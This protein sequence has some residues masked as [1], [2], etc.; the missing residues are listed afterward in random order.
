LPRGIEGRQQLAPGVRLGC[1][2]PHWNLQ[3][4]EHR[5][6]L[7]AARHNLRARQRG[8][9]R[10]ARTLPLD[11]FEQRARADAGEQNDDVELIA[12]QS[13]GKG[14]RF[15]VGVE[16]HFAQRGRDDRTAAI[17]CDERRHLLTATAFE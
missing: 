1:R 14:E 11:D 16:R 13:I 17:G 6:R 12:E 3:L 4:A 15:G 9:E 5:Q 2:Y 10:V 7:G 8:N